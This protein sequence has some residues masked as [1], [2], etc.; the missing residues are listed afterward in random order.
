MINQSVLNRAEKYREEFQSAEPFRHVVIDDFL[1]PA[2]AEQML[3][4]FP[5]FDP[6]KAL[7]EMGEVGNK[8]VFEN[9]ADISP[10]YRR[11]AAH[12]QSQ[13]FLEA[14]SAMTGVENLLGDPT[15][16][17]GGTHENLEGQELD[18]HVDFNYDERTWVHRRL[19][20]LL[21]LNKEWEDAWGGSIEL[22]SDPRR[23]EQNRVKVVTPLFN[24]CLIF[25]TNERSWH[26]FSV[27]R[28]PPDKRHLSRKSF[29]L[30][31]Y[32]RERPAEELAPPHSTF[33]I[34]RPLPEHIRPGQPLSHEDYETIRQLIFKRDRFI[35]YYQ[36]RELEHG[37]TYMDMLN[38]LKVADSTIFNFRASRSWRLLKPLRKVK[39]LIY[40]MRRGADGGTQ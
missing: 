39:H 24:R 6:A 2:A 5:V 14:V 8:A 28:L 3:R 20:L 11:L 30:Y 1:E 32:T 36:K 25:E 37:Q 23:P 10:F 15:L 22:H 16:F 33:Y 40:G 29:S 18:P 31:L 26:G 38:R 7:N 12:V 17:G 34:Q 19:N 21:Y 13:E 9:V 35:E 27:I 4:D